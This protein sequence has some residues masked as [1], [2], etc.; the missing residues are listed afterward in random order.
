MPYALT[1]CQVCHEVLL[2]ARDDPDAGADAAGPRPALVLWPAPDRVLSE[3]IPPRL[4]REIQ[5][6]RAS[7][8]AGAYASA[9]VMVRRL[10]EGVCADQ[11]VHRTPLYAALREMRREGLVDGRLLAWAE[12]MRVLGNEGAHFGGAPVGREDAEDAL[13]LAEALLDYLYVHAHRYAA[14]RERRGEPPATSGQPGDDPP[15][16]LALRRA[17]AEYTEHP[18]PHDP[19][20]TPSQLAVADVLGVPRHQMYKAVVAYV[21]EHVV[22]ALVPVDAA[23]DLA[24]LAAVTGGGTAR[25]ATA[26]E[27]TGFEVVSPLGLPLRVPT[28]LDASVLVLDT[29]YVASGRP[30]LEL[31]VTRPDLVRLTAATTAPISR[32]RQ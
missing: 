4:R 27:V 11:G 15:A 18:Y 21:D 12:G 23:V 19:A 5:E 28:V 17:G 10:L 3:L 1:V 8:R 29:V 22:L 9:V 24:A 13:Y 6:S 14:F 2:L 31:Q 7:V 20:R 25:I 32:P 16:V 26:T 30:G